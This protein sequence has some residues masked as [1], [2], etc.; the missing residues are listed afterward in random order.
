M[1]GI[2][3]C[4]YIYFFINAVFQVTVHLYDFKLDQTVKKKS[5]YVDTFYLISCTT[6]CRIWIPMTDPLLWKG[7]A[8]DFK[9]LP[10]TL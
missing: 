8:S 4:M 9:Y 6:L 5:L 2:N 10:W 3:F 1:N 7:S